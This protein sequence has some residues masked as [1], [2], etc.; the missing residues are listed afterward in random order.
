MGASAR[1][2]RQ[3]NDT[4]GV[5]SVVVSHDV[6]ETFLIADHVVF[7]ANGR[8]AAQGTPA[9]M[10]ATNDPLVRQFIDAEAD[11]PVR[12]HYPA[13]TVAEDFRLEA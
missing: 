13:S 10:R 4:L 12:F 6:D 2:I 3:L 5:T 11:G 7:L 8:I 1:L 9:E